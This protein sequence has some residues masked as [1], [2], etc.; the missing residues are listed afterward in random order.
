M[1]AAV[2]SERSRRPILMR[3]AISTVS[4]G[5]ILE[6]EPRGEH[7]AVAAAEREDGAR[8]GA[9]RG[10]ERVEDLHV[11]GHRL[12]A[13]SA[14]VGRNGDRDGP[15]WVVVANGERRWGGGDGVGW[16]DGPG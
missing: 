14:A 1:C 2:T 7:P 4:R 9:A 3:H 13:R 15:G 10:L 16:G 5:N 12:R 11:V 6:A 8:V